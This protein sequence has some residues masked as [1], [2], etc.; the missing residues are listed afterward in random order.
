MIPH[1]CSLAQHRVEV[2]G[3]LA[4]V[5]LVLVG[6]HTLILNFTKVV[7]FIENTK[8]NMLKIIILYQNKNLYFGRDRPQLH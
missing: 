7:N 6:Y 8:F 1:P 2:L 4:R 3:L 5:E